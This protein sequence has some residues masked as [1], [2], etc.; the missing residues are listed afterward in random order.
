MRGTN[1]Y[2]IRRL[3]VGNANNNGRM[4]VM[5]WTKVKTSHVLSECRKFSDKEFRAWVEILALTA[6]LE[7]IPDRDEILQYVH[8][9]TLT[10]LQ[11]RLKKAAREAQESGKKGPRSLED[12]LVKVLEDVD[13][14]NRKKKDDAERKQRKRDL[15]AGK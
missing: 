14:T 12:M 3:G 11:E 10:S 13:K 8:H 5:D 1:N 15:E 7:R 6:S 2:R 9:K 4:K